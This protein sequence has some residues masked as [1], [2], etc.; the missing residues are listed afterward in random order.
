MEG[1]RLLEIQRRPV[2]MV[3]IGD[4]LT[5]GMQ[6]AC[7][8]ARAQD[9]AYTSQMARQADIPYNMPT[10]DEL[11]IPARLFVG[12]DVDLPRAIKN[13]T[14][15]GL[16]SAA[17]MAY[18]TLLG[19]PPSALMEPLYGVGDMGER[20][21]SSKDRPGHPQHNLAVPGYELRHMN[22]V[23]HV[24]DWMQEVRD[25]AS[26]EL[27]FP[28]LTPLIHSVI[29]NGENQALGSEVDQ[30]V[31]K[32]PDLIVL[33]PGNNDALEPVTGGVVDDRRLT[34]LEDKKWK[35]W[36]QNP[37]TGKWTQRET[38]EV[39]KGFR[40]SLH[41]LVDRLERETS[42]EIMLFNIPPVTVIPFLREV[43][44]K[45]G[46]L[47][48]SIVLPDGTDVTRWIENLTLPTNVDGEGKNGR[49]HFPAGTRIGLGMILKQLTDL[50]EPQSFADFELALKNFEDKAAFGEND[51][52]DPD[53]L[54]AITRRID[55]YNGLTRELAETHPRIHLVDA[56][57]ALD[58]A[59]LNGRALRGAGGDVTVTN[60]F[61]GLQDGRG[62]GGIFSFDGIHPS[63][64]GHSVLGNMLL[65]RIQQDLGG[66][67]KFEHFL[68]VPFIDEKAVY[69]ADPHHKGKE[70]RLVLSRG[71]AGRLQA[72][73]S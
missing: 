9:M 59:R 26:R 22:D 18:L 72:L 54:G 2:R 28:V 39:R 19:I 17:P 8:D 47:P 11:G 58:E 37:V 25:G 27:L 66:Q 44:A 1:V 32:R 57:R 43:G 73:P 29:Q 60:T 30:A 20:S 62:H 34:P 5:A 3:A 10:I 35:Y 16:A 69:A 41:E 13:Y 24:N 12:Q 63:D 31:A 15:L 42:A 65:D 64:V 61:T 71:T 48:F 36:D 68:S 55:Q 33:W 14:L 40:R 38:K 50:F 4:S 6:D 7:L 70:T 49:T 53:E 67:K 45:V 46:Q 51:V 52:L 21:A 23:T 56:H